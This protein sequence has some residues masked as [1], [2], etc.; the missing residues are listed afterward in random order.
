[1]STPNNA[2]LDEINAALEWWDAAG[3][4]FDFTDDATAW[5]HSGASDGGGQTNSHAD[6]KH[7]NAQDGPKNH[8]TGNAKKET[9]PAVTRQNLLGDT[10]PNTLD[11]FHQFWLEAP[12]LDAIGPRGRVPPR[13]PANTEL[14]VLVIDP[15]QG[16]TTHLLSGPQGQL[17]QKML[18]AMRIDEERVY[19]A[20]AMPRH[21]PMA[22]TENLAAGGLD[23]VLRHHIALA[24]P[25]RLVAFG[26]GLVPLLGTDVSNAETSLRENNQA[27]ALPPILMSKGLESL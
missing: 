5:F 27:V 25:K 26:A 1:M 19:I 8:A 24:A 17:L 22:D 10:P 13:G 16:D 20:S 21:T 15:E 14:M 18:K 4:D 9:S 11:E 2:F 23:D 3:V 7:A 12:G 6:T